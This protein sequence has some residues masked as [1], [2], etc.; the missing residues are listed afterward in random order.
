MADWVRGEA[1]GSHSN[2]IVHPPGDHDSFAVGESSLAA[3]LVG[4][5]VIHRASIRPENTAMIS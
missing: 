1:A 5:E 4:R 3:T 2:N